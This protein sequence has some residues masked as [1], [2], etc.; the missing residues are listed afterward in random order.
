MIEHET[1]LVNHYVSRHEDKANS[2]FDRERVMK[3]IRDDAKTY[4]DAYY[5]GFVVAV[6]NY[7]ERERHRHELLKSDPRSRES[8]YDTQ[9]RYWTEED[10]R[11]WLS[12]KLWE[13]H[14]LAE[15][16]EGV[17]MH[18]SFREFAEKTATWVTEE[19]SPGIIP[20]NFAL[21]ES[22]I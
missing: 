11:K 5:H 4:K 21:L 22:C 8:M 2:W 1:K 13:K 3:M 20:V 19:H 14:E 7:N 12:M 18:E 9:P 16:V 10:L 6:E 17:P 15:E